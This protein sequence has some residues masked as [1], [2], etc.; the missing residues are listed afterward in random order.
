MIPNDRAFNG[1][2]FFEFSGKKYYRW[3]YLNFDRDYCFCFR[4]ISTKSNNKQ[5]ITL[6]FADFK[7]NILCNGRPMAI[8]K[9]KFGNYLFKADDIV[10]DEVSVSVQPRE[11]RLFLGNASERG[12]LGI[13]TSGAFGCAFWIE[14]I[15]NNHYRFH[16]NDHE[17]DDDFD[18]LVFDLIIS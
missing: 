14:T 17:Y 4:I 15:K 3:Y 7:G 9:N 16:C 13:F 10:N 8:P 5:G 18:D 2:E 1:K 11:G 6:H 12:E